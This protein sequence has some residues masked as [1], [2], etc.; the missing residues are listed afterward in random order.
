MRRAFLQ[1]PP[2]RTE[3]IGTL[4][5][6]V[7]YCL[8]EVLDA[9][10][11]GQPAQ[12]GAFLSGEAI[13]GHSVAK[14]NPARVVRDDRSIH[15]IYDAPSLPLRPEPLNRLAAIQLR[16]DAPGDGFLVGMSQA[17]EDRMPHP[18]VLIVDMVPEL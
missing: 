8:Q 10:G 13:H 18:L 17:V 16:D 5:M 4:V 2:R 12:L 7:P 6:A 11:R 15:Q 9:P 1:H 3:H 14:R